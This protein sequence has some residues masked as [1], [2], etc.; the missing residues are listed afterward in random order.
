MIIKKRDTQN[1]KGINKPGTPAIPARE[2][3]PATPAECI[4]PIVCKTEEIADEMIRRMDIEGY[5][6]M[7]DGQKYPYGTDLLIQ[8]KAETREELLEAVKTCK[9]DEY[10]GSSD[11]E[12]SESDL[13]K[14]DDIDE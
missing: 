12:L 6:A 5:Q 8:F 4:L 9:S 10:N 14:A 2:A 1:L 7:F 11:S 13:K 3:V